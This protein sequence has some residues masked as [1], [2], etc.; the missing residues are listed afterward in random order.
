MTTPELTSDLPFAMPE[1]APSAASRAQP[2]WYRSA[3][4]FL[5]WALLHSISVFPRNPLEMRGGAQLVPLFPPVWGLLYNLALAGVFVWWFVLR[6]G[7]EAEYRRETFRLNAPPVQAMR[8]LPLVAASLVLTVFTSLV[9]VPRVIPF[10][11]DKGDPLEAYLK[12]PFGLVTVLSLASIMVPLVEEF[13]F[14]G[15]VQTRLERKLSPALA[16]AIAATVFGIVHFQLFGLPV[17]IVFGLTA[18]YYAWATRSIW[19]GVL[20][21]AIYNGVLLGGGT[22][23]P[24]VD[25][26]TLLR[27]SHTPS[28]FFPCLAGFALGIVAIIVLLRGIEPVRATI[29]E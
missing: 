29:A 8:R 11:A 14:R 3:G 20:L 23:T 16:I 6:G 21:H 9:V 24:G 27:W 19:P 13:L 18:G 25:E 4:A 15:W 10:P 2:A 7:S 1:P 22:A 17:R 28:I 12:L 5:L 26:H